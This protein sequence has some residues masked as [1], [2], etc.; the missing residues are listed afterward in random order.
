MPMHDW[1][2]VE[3]GIYHAFHHEWISEIGRALNRGLLPPDH[4]AL[5]EQ[6][7]G[8]FGPDVL[9]LHE[10]GHASAAGDPAGKGGGI[11]LRARPQTSY[12]AE[13]EGDF[14][15]RKQKAIVV[16]HVSG[17]EIVAVIEIVAPGNKS[18]RKAFRD[19]LDKA[20]ELL[21]QRI[22]LLIIDP[23]PPGPRDPEGVHGALW[24]DLQGDS[25][26]LPEERRLTLAAYECA[27]S[28]RAYIEPIAVGDAL[29][30]MPLFLKPDGCVMVPLE[31][32]YTTAF[33]CL[34]G[35]WREVLQP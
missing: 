32:T 33:D 31:A 7:A 22:H 30:D 12:T 10:K 34:P 25:F 15:R 13:A 28:T 3:A 26:H 20:Y 21:E 5:P 14:Y 27:G 23:L 19:F 6:F 11:T 1:T 17:D 9:A 8:K 4:Y 29:P 18:S 16:R 24:E 35:R 2:R